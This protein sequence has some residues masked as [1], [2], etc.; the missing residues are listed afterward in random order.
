MI[1]GQTSGGGNCILDTFP[2]GDGLP[3]YISGPFQMVT[4]EFKNTDA[5]TIPDK[6][7]EI[8]TND[9]GTLDYSAFYDISALS[10]YINE[11]YK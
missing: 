8:K 4:R 9:D 1:L 2:L 6:E 3:C 5:G 11:F 10:R 7:L